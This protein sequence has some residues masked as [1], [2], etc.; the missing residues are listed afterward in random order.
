MAAR[1]HLGTRVRGRLYRWWSGR[2]DG[3][4]SGW[5][6]GQEDE[7]S[8]GSISRVAYAAEDEAVLAQRRVVD[9][10]GVWHCI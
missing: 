2:R 5:T 9:D 10:G 3:G 6:L 4:S 7:L 8:A 1:D